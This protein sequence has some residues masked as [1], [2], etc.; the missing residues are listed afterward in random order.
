MSDLARRTWLAV[1]GAFDSAPVWLRTTSSHHRPTPGLAL[2]IRAGSHAAGVA[3]PTS[4][5]DLRGVAIAPKSSYLGFAHGFARFTRE[6]PAPDC[7]VVDLPTFFHEAAEGHV[8]ALQVLFC[9]DDDV[10]ATSHV[11]RLLRE[12]RKAFLSR[13]MVKPFVGYAKSQI[14]AVEQKYRFS[15]MTGNALHE[16]TLADLAKST[17]HAVRLVRMVREA[18]ATGDLTVHRPDAGE[19]VELRAVRDIEALLARCEALGQELADLP[20]WVAESILPERPDLEVLD[21]TCVQVL[22]DSFQA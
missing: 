1:Q 5:V 13:R 22:S 17:M 20:S 15:A 12:Q 8:D 3:L 2:L 7:E 6:A 10:L 21:R 18:L 19:L 4:D 11:G 9:R 14:A 16:R